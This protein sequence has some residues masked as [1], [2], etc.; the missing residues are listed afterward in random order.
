MIGTE[1]WIL[2]G[3]YGLVILFLSAIGAMYGKANNWAIIFLFI[4]G[5]V[6]FL[7]MLLAVPY[8]AVALGGCSMAF[9]A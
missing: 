4:F 8:L 9:V 5:M 3:F 1:T 7:I 2:F 6:G